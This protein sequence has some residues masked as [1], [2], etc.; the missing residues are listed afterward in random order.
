MSVPWVF[1]KVLEP[2]SLKGYQ[3]R[4]ACGNSFVEKPLYEMA[5]A[6][7]AWLLV[8]I[9]CVFFPKRLWTLCRKA[10]LVP[11]HV[12]K[13]WTGEWNRAQGGNFYTN[14][15]FCWSCSRSE[16]ISTR[17]NLQYTS[18]LVCVYIYL[19]KPSYCCCPLHHHGWVFVYTWTQA[20]LSPSSSVQWILC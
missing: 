11:D 6:T 3:L 12:C 14:D 8:V 18:M 9:K 17:I 4:E 19:R 13:L 1:T 7:S 10:D 20:S 5:A 15:C 2:V 16:Y